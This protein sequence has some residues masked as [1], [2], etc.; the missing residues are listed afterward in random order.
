MFQIFIFRFIIFILLLIYFNFQFI[1]II[2]ILFI[3]KFL[4]LNYKFIHDFLPIMSV[5]ECFII[6]LI[7][8]NLNIHYVYLNLLIYLNHLIIT[9]IP[10]IIQ[11]HILY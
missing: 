6:H 2:I 4:H 8:G 3:F 10:Q 1:I 9:M 7:I 11:F 5:Y